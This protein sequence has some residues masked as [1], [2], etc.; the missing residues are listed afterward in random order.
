MSFSTE[1]ITFGCGS[2]EVDY[3]YDG[4][5]R[6]AYVE[7]DGV[8]VEDASMFLMDSLYELL[9]EKLQRQADLAA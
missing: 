2:F 7:E 9:A 6:I 3:E 4:E 1:T 5:F 8:E